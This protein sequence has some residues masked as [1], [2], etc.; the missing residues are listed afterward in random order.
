MA[1]HLTDY[2]SRMT[3]LKD[4]VEQHIRAYLETEEAMRSGWRTIE[5][6]YLSKLGAEKPEVMVYGIFNAGK[7]SIINE[8]IGEDFAKVADIPTTDAVTKY[9]WKGYQIADTPGVGA[10][11]EHEK[12]TQDH[13]TRADVVIFVMSTTGSNEKR[14]NYERMKDIADAGKKV[15]VVLND[16]NGDL[17]GDDGLRNIQ[18]IKRKVAANMKSVGI[19]DRYHIVTVNADWARDGRINNDQKLLELSGMADLASVIMQELKKTNRFTIW[20]TAVRSAAKA[21]EPMIK[22]LE[23]YSSGAGVAWATEILGKLNSRKKE[24]RETMDVYV[25]GLTERLGSE[26]ALTLWNHRDDASKAD[27]VWQDAVAGL[28]GKVMKK[29]E[30][31]IKELIQE[32]K[33]DAE[34]FSQ[35]IEALDCKF[36]DVS[37]LADKTS[38]CISDTAGVSAVLSQLKDKLQDVDD[39]LSGRVQAPAGESPDIAAQIG[40]GTMA[41]EAAQMAVGK[42]VASEVGKKLLATTIGAKLATFIPFIGP[43]VGIVTCLAGLFSFGGGNRGDAD[44][45]AQAAA[46]NEREQRRVEQ[47][48]QAHQELNQICHYKA[49]DIA[50]ELKNSIDGILGEISGQIAQPFREQRKQLNESAQKVQEDL[51]ALRDLAD[52]YSALYAEM[53]VAEAAQ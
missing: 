6:A 5:Q 34:E 25:D 30:N 9:E 14:E 27:S 41:S 3:V 33:D 45:R 50:L 17:Y 19:G 20:C 15:I 36:D 24:I 49:G 44:L 18:E 31:E 7:S 4:A 29:L 35:K 38:Q 37:G 51:E 8:L 26:L 40:Q 21:L 46:A 10:P 11:I 28:I 12:V 23:N 2:Q 1:Y 48:H 42:F 53:K 39:E 13:L 32:L 16:K 47:E 52:R 22:A 43:I